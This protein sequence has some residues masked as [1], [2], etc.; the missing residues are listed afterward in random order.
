M[1]FEKKR[2]EGLPV[3]FENLLERLAG[4]ALLNLMKSFPK[5][6]K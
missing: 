4:L 2:T 6:P 1:A 3:F 5:T